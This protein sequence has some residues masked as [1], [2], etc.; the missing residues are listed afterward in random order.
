LS[1]FKLSGFWGSLQEEF[2][3]LHRFERWDFPVTAKEDKI[4]DRLAEGVLKT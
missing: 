3:E 4:F 1:T 2:P